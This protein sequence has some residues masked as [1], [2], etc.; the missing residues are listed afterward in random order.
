MGGPGSGN[1][2]PK[3]ENLR[4]MKPIGEA[5]LGERLS[6]RFPKEVEAVLNR[7]TSSQKQAY[8][9]SAVEEKMKQEGLL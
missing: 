5:A 4:P 6:V 7:M 8:I 1:P 3:I 2:N 9:R